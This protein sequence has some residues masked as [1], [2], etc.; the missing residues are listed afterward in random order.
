MKTT[1]TISFHFQ[2][3]NEMFFQLGVSECILL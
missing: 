3:W 1:E 2:Y